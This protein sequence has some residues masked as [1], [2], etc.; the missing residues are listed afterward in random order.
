MYLEYREKKK[1]H[2]ILTTSLKIWTLPQTKISYTN[3][4]SMSM[5][6][7][8][9]KTT[10][11]FSQEWQRVSI[12]SRHL[13]IARWASIS[14]LIII[15]GVIVIV[16]GCLGRRRKRLHEATKVSLPSRN[17]ADMGVHLIQLITKSIKVSIKASIHALKLHHDRMKSHTTSRGRRSRGGWSWRSE[18]SC[19]LCLGSPRF[20]LR[21]I[22]SNGSNIYVTH[23][24]KMREKGNRNGKMAKNPRD[25]WRKNELIMGRHIL[26]D[27][28]KG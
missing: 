1:I 24:W 9:S 28:Y 19:R 13:I 22:S 10:H 14:I 20:E 25:S 7:L 15:V 12:L 27:I 3:P 16:L 4:P 11:P 2:K 23:H 26:V 21:L 18:R 6:T 8:I 5:T 17:R